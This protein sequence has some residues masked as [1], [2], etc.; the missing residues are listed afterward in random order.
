MRNDSMCVWIESLES[1]EG[2]EK[3]HNDEIKTETEREKKKAF[4]DSRPYKKDEFSWIAPHTYDM[5]MN[6]LPH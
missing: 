1:C 2:F 4:M 3:I 6:I 5:M